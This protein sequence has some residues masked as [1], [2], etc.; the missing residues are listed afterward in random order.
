V[1]PTATVQTR[2]IHTVREVPT[3][4]GGPSSAVL[5]KSRLWCAV[6][7]RHLRSFGGTLSKSRPNGGKVES[8]HLENGGI[9]RI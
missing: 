5:S 3:L 6:P 7:T 4:S 1:A 9:P 8:L 2:K